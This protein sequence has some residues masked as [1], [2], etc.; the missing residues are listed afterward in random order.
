MLTAVV[1]M[2][3]GLCAKAEAARKVVVL[4][5]AWVDV[6]IRPKTSKVWDG[7]AA[8][9]LPFQFPPRRLQE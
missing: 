7:D 6:E 2:G 4:C 5:E 3:H 9:I 8:A 1:M